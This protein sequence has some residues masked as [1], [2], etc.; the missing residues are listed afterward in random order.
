MSDEEPT[1]SHFTESEFNLISKFM[2]FKYKT[3]EEAKFEYDA[4]K[5]AIDNREEKLS[6]TKKEQK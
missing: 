3:F 6:G 1:Q 4:I 5:G 2:D